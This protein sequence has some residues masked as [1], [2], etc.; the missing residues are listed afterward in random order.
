MRKNSKTYKDLTELID[1]I[2]ALTGER[3]SAASSLLKEIMFLSAT[4]EKLKAQITAE[5]PILKTDK[6]ARENPALKA[7]N[8]SIQRYSL[9][10]KQV[11]DLLP[12]PQREPPKDPLIEF[13]KGGT[14]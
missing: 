7:Y 10:F 12:E 14:V 11:V 5:G 3:K 4:L 9:L 1:G 13:A 8:A 6:T 2:E